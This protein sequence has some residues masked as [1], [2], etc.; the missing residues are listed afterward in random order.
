MVFVNGALTIL[1]DPVVTYKANLGPRL[2][3]DIPIEDFIYGTV[4]LTWI[5]LRWIKYTRN[6]IEAK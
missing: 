1:D 5:L 4:L 2:F 6:E 3:F